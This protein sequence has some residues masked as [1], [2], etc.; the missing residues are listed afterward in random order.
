LAAGT[1]G[2]AASLSWLLRL[3]PKLADAL[4]TTFDLPTITRTVSFLTAIAGRPKRLA[5]RPGLARSLR[6]LGDRAPSAASP[7]HS[8]LERRDSGSASCGAR[9]ARRRRGGRGGIRDAA[10]GD[11]TVRAGSDGQPRGGAAERRRPVDRAEDFT[12]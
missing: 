1:I 6:L 8:H 11:A 12:F 9:R 5:I 3:S 2:A 7:R 10:R 4:P